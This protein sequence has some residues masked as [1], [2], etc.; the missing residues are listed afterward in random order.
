MWY[1]RI[2]FFF[3]FFGLHS[4]GSRIF[5]FRIT[6]KTT[7]FLL[8]DAEEKDEEKKKVTVEHQRKKRTGLTSRGYFNTANRDVMTKMPEKAKKEVPGP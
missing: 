7:R 5:R 2:F 1:W 3:F 6:I 8:S 4:Y